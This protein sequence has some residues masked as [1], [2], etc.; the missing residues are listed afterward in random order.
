MEKKYLRSKEA[1]AYLGIGH[2]T[3]W[4]WVGEKKFT[5]IKLSKT[6]TVFRKSELDSFIEQCA[7]VS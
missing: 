7:E 6:I 1:S 3:F 5:P 4:R 2:S